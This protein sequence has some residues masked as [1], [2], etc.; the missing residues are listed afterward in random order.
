[1]CVRARK[2]AFPLSQLISQLSCDLCSAE[3]GNIYI[4]YPYQDITIYTVSSEILGIV[5]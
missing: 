3:L 4:I 2:N 1:M 5:L